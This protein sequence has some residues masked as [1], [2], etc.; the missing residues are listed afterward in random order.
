MVFARQT[1]YYSSHQL[2]MLCSSLVLCSREVWCTS[3]RSTTSL[4]VLLCIMCSASSYCVSTYVLLGEVVVYL[5]VTSCFI[6]SYSLA[7]TMLG[8]T[9]CVVLSYG[10]V[11]VVEQYNTK[12]EALLHTRTDGSSTMLCRSSTS[13]C[14]AAASTSYITMA[15]CITLSISP[16]VHAVLL[17][18]PS[19]LPITTT[20][21]RCTSRY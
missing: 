9:T 2:V 20:G 17:I 6:I 15:L 10:V 14:S 4:V 19:L 16:S 21:R 3:S 1:Y 7:S 13:P 18:P 12:G 11:E 5:L 8:Y